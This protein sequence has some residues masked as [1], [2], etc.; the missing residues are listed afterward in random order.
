VARSS[1]AA[2]GPTAR[3]AVC[4][5]VVGLQV[6]NSALTGE[7][8]PVHSTV[9]SS[10]ANYLESTNIAFLSSVHVKTKRCSSDKNK[11]HEVNAEGG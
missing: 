9:Q 7:S 1:E 4:L 8:E 6:N 5:R 3:A 2:L 11:R 10:S